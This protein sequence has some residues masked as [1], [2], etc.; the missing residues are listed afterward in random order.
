[1]K[2]K[3]FIENETNETSPKAGLKN[4]LTLS[5]AL[6]IFATAAS[7]FTAAAAVYISREQ[8]K[9][10]DQQLKLTRDSGPATDKMI[11]AIQTQAVEAGKQ[12][13]AAK[14]LVSASR[15]QLEGMEKMTFAA[16]QQNAI[17]R[18]QT[19]SIKIQA[20]AMLKI[21]STNQESAKIAKNQEQIMGQTTY[22]SLRP[23]LAIYFS[24][25]FNKIKNSE[26]V[27]IKIIIQNN[28]KSIAIDSKT[29]TLSYIS[30]KAESI[31]VNECI[32]TLNKECQL[33]TVQ[34]NSNYPI[35]FET[36]KMSHDLQYYI[37]GRYYLTIFTRVDYR[38]V[39]GASHYTVEC[40]QYNFSSNRWSNCHHGSFA[41]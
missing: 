2:K 32:E 9:I 28:G 23:L 17:S 29:N 24:P 14:N 21:V 1:M 25:E 37:S 15:A 7:V 13:E 35:F 12:A 4:D 20:N 16:S 33:I 22:I 27:K 38:D 19:N 39:F 31:L 30:D 36:E 18:E 41:T 34:P 40:T 10:Y 6:L 5:S 3:S 8:L 11:L 26:P